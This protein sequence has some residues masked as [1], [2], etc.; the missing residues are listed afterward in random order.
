[1][2]KGSKHNQESISKMK[3][4]LKGNTPW[5]KGKTDCKKS[6]HSSETKLKISKSHIGIRP[7]EKTRNLMKLSQ[8]KR[9]EK[10][11]ERNKLVIANLGKKLPIE[12]RLK[13]SESR[14]GEKSSFWK[15]GITEINQKI[16][17]SLEIKLWREAVF[18]RDNYTCIWCGDNSGGNLNADHIKPFSLFPE[19]RFDIN[20]GRTLCVSCHKKTDTWGEKVKHYK[21]AV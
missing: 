14:K 20:N 13:M 18:K 21:P 7:N 1:M 11:E 9:F 5:N 10:P 16:R 17:N 8:K 2:K 6:P 4:S 3:I 19:L 12:T 15:G